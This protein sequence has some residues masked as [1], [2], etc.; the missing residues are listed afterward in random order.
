MAKCKMFRTRLSFYRFLEAE[1]DGFK[2]F[3]SMRVFPKF[4]LVD[5]NGES[6]RL[7]T[8][9]RFIQKLNE[10][11]GADYNSKRSYSKGQAYMLFFGEV[12][13]EDVS[14]KQSH[15]Q[16]APKQ[17]PVASP[18]EV[19]SDTPEEV[20]SLISLEEDSVV[21]QPVVEECL[22]MEDTKENRK[23]VQQ[24]AKSH[25]VSLKLS[26]KLSTMLETLDEKG[27]EFK[28]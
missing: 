20:S 26:Q 23:K 16:E 9:R 19:C 12:A 18:E 11:F 5:K 28:G 24:F 3:D 6:H 14:K 8:M 1:L 2:A 7:Y 17:E 13:E 10:E 21:E 22:E 4:G 15:K 25:G 27:I